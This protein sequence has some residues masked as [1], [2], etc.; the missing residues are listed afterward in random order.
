MHK[1]LGDDKV[2]DHW[3]I[4]GSYPGAAH[5]ERNLMYRISKSGWKLPVFI[6]S[7][8]GYD[9]YLVGKAL[10]N[11]FGKVRVIPHNMKKYRSLT[12]GRLKFI[13]AF[14]FT[15]KGLDVLAKTLAD[16]EF[17]D[18]RE[19]PTFWSHPTRRCLSL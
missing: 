4:V 12:V 16:D 7:L 19:S 18:L 2:R 8:K 13:D 5:N 11:E 17:R 9:G 14:Q 6:H 3:H 15:P 10:K 1:P